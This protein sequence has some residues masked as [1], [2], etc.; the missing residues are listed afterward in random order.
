MREDILERG[1]DPSLFPILNSK[2]DLFSELQWIWEAYSVLTQSRQFGMSSPQPIPISEI[3]AYAEFNDVREST[4][5][6]ELLHFVQHL[7][8]VFLADFSARNTNKTPP[9]SAATGAMR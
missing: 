1:E 8:S 6:E 7:D 5:R 9:P 2:P 4:D 3:L